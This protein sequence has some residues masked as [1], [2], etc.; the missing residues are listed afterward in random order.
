MPKQLHTISINEL[1]MRLQSRGNLM[2]VLLLQ[3]T[4]YLQMRLRPRAPAHAQMILPFSKSRGLESGNGSAR[5]TCIIA[6]SALITSGTRSVYKRMVSN[7]TKQIVYI[8]PW[9]NFPR[10]DEKFTLGRSMRRMRV[11][12]WHKLE[13]VKW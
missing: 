8:N 3:E 6:R 2:D 12:S 7:K 4:A 13:I 1:N 5:R 11:I 9:R 10:H